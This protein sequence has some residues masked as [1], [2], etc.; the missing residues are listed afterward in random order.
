MID[1]LLE[2]PV[3]FRT[4]NFPISKSLQTRKFFTINI[5]GSRKHLNHC[6][7]LHTL[8]YTNILMI[9][10]IYVHLHCKL[11]IVLSLATNKLRQLRVIKT[12]QKK[13][14]LRDIYAKH[15]HM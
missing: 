11:K 14:I 1:Q 13:K 7:L 6:E 4:I 3:S 9:A 15:T 10:Y 2:F 8:D 5:D 12:Y